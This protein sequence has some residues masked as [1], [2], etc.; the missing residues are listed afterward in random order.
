M[1]SQ[2]DNETHTLIDFKHFTF[3]CVSV[4]GFTVHDAMHVTF[5]DIFP[6][7]FESSQDEWD[8]TSVEDAD[9][10][11]WLRVLGDETESTLRCYAELSAE[12]EFACLVEISHSLGLMPNIDCIYTRSCFSKF[13]RAADR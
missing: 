9:W 3:V 13:N 5:S 6:S 11:S 7:S 8:A 2:R 1:V 10:I 12:C 4:H